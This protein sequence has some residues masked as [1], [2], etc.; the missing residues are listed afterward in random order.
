[1]KLKTKQ[2]RP[3]RRLLGGES[4]VEGDRI[5]PLES[6]RQPLKQ[7]RCFPG[8]FSDGPAPAP[9]PLLGCSRSQ[10]SLWQLERRCG[11]WPAAC[12]WLPYYYFFNP[13]VLN[14]RR[15]SVFGHTTGR[16]E[17]VPAHQVLLCHINLSLGHISEQGWRSRPGRPSTR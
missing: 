8:V 12:I 9:I 17:D 1:L 4:A 11:C 5:S 10:L 3:Q 13:S 15:N 14:S 2:V 7:V 16:S 6:H